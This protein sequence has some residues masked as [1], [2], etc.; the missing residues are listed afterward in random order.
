MVNGPYTGAYVPSG[1]RVVLVVSTGPSGAPQPF[2]SVPSVV[3]APQEGALARLHS[4]GLRP[5]VV[6]DY[7][8]S[9]PRGRVIA[10]LP[11]PGSA[12]PDEGSVLLVSAGPA[13]GSPPEVALPDVT[14]L[15]EAEAVATIESVGLSA[16]IVREPSAMVAA[17][18][19]VAQLPGREVVAV[20]RRVSAGR[21]WW[22][23]VLA[24]VALLVLLAVAAWLLLR[25]GGTVPDVVGM[26][27]TEA[28]TAVAQAGFR[29]DIRPAEEAGEYAAGFVADQTPDGGTDARRGSTV[30]L[31]VVAGA[32]TIEVP[33]VVGLNQE[34][35]SSR[36]SQAGFRVNVIEQPDEDVDPGDVISQRPPAGA[37]LAPASAV[38]IVVSRE[39][40]AEAVLVPQVTGLVV[41]DADDTLVQAGFRVIVVENPSGDVAEGAVISQ[42][43]ASGEQA[44]PGST[45]ALIVSS[46]PAE[47]A[48]TVEV[49]NV[50][51]DTLPDAQAALAEDGLRSQ[52]VAVDGSEE[53]ANTVIAQMPSGGSA[54][55]PDS[56]VVLFYA[57]G[58]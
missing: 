38:T 54:V 44:M 25:T 20:E 5:R 43:P 27:Q 18:V 30:V 32:E 51:G 56:T 14:G 36:L 13:P 3:G 11:E 35:A 26:S 10:Q 29:P 40:E 41:A 23:W 55:S 2:V 31:F 53:D 39:P 24:A 17:G 4:A 52:P 7:S 9:V 16:Q 42:L 6:N 57:T 37:Q 12:A 33:D 48:T 47:D 15:P 46:G 21:S 34:T 19:V 22:P 8:P 28:V 1:S 50:V 58:R 49:Q 45:V